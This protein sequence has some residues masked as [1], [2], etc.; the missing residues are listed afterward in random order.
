LNETDAQ[1][2]G[3]SRFCPR[4]G[5]ATDAADRFCRSCGA[6]LNAPVDAGQRD[7][8]KTGVEPPLPETSPER[9]VGRRILAALG[10]LLLV[11]AVAVGVLLA[12]GALTGGSDQ[13]DVAIDPAAE[14]AFT[15]E[16]AFRDEFYKAERAYLQPL[17]QANGEL[18]RYQRKDRSYTAET[19][20]IEEEFADEF[21]ACL[22]FAAVPCP[23][24]TYPTAPEVPNFGQE[25]KQMRAASQQFGELRAQLNSIQPRYGISALHTQ[26]LAAIEAMQAEID[27]NADVFDEAA[28]APGE[29]V[30]GGLDKGKLKTLRRETALPSIRQ[31]N[32]A[33]LR[34]TRRFRQALRT[35]DLPGGR[36]LDPDDHSQ[37]I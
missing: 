10:L 12:T 6:D 19:K 25:T 11:G 22:R 3:A 24:P 8:D 28:Q 7:A 16:M 14:R 13:D 33:A 31:M 32:Q 26:L 30:S 27:H 5:E 35:Y 1:S 2:G 29:D 17:E 37:A 4:C 18:H 15:R 34:A 36:D 23:E 20:R 9:S 21:D